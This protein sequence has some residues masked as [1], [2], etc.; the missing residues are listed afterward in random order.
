MSSLS[1]R[2]WRC[3]LLCSRWRLTFQLPFLGFSTQQ[4]PGSERAWT[5]ARPLWSGLKC[6][7]YPFC[8]SVSPSKSHDQ[9]DTRGAPLSGRSCKVTFQGVWLQEDEGVSIVCIPPLSTVTI[10][11]CFFFS[12]P[13]RMQ[14]NAQT[15][16]LRVYES[17]LNHPG[18]PAVPLPLQTGIPRRCL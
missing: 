16:S 10:G 14:Q 3:W 12:C 17:P 2:G 15:R 5:C 1:G 4:R 9:S 6:A 8:P 11:N 7:G 13:R 18:L